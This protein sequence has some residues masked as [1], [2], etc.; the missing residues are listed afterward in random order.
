MQDSYPLTVTMILI[1]I[2][3]LG[4]LSV[5]TIYMFTNRWRQQKIR[6]W[7]AAQLIEERESTIR[8]GDQKYTFVYS[9]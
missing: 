9:Y 6:N 4:F 8:R 2:G 5:R 7:T 1:A 3:M